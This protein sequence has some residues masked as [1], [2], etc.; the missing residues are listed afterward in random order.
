LFVEQH[1]HE[2]LLLSEDSML[3]VHCEIL[4]GFLII[5]IEHISKQRQIRD[6]CIPLGMSSVN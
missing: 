3:C 6:E 1:T 5:Y 4:I 2:L